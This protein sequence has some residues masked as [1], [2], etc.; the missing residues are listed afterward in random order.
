VSVDEVQFVVVLFVVFVTLAAAV[1]LAIKRTAIPYSVALVGVGLFMGAFLPELEVTVTPDIVLMVLLPGLVFEASIHVDVSALRRSLGS[2]VLLAG[3]G[4]IVVAVA[5]A[6][7]LA[8]GAGLP[9][10][11]GLIVGSMVA[12]TDPAAVLATFKRLGVPGRLAAMVEGESLFNDGTGLVLFALTLS[13]LVSTVTAVDLVWTLVVTVVVSLAI[14]LAAGWL[15]ARILA[16]VD[17]HLLQLTISVSVAYGTYLLADLFHESG[18]IATVIA[19]IVIGN[20]GRRVGISRQSAQTLDTVW[21]FV[22]FLLTALAFMIVGLS[23]SVPGLIDGLPWIAWGVIGV[24]AGRAVVVYG[25]LGGALWVGRR[26]SWADKEAHPGWL[27]VLYWSGLRGAVAVAMALSLPT[28]VP[29]RQLLLEI[30]FGIV[31]FT[32]VV[33]G[34]TI[35]PLVRRWLHLRPR[36]P[37]EVAS[38]APSG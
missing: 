31:L 2:V 11:L 9:T 12:A 10:E 36:H 15:A 37:R 34:M 26:T 14:G 18:V 38:E 7:A 17:D 4:V 23:I 35:E 8:V 22:A 32:L 5:V 3:P 13:A 21:E 20:H 27:H 1:G 28:S 30:T 29:E 19:G 16:S 6:V 25:L 33:Q 24:L